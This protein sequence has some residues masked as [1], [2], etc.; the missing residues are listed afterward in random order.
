[1]QI[2]KEFANPGGLGVVCG[3][4]QMTAIL[5]L[6]S[7]TLPLYDVICKRSLIFVKRCLTSENDL[8]N[9]V[10]HYGVLYGGMSSVLGCNV[11]SCSRRYQL[12]VNYL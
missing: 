11:M 5:Q 6:L 7:D 4:Y 12:P 10:S 1:M 2:L 3:V 9:F 8:V